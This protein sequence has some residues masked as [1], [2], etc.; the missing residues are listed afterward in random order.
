MTNKSGGIKLRYD[1]LSV[2]PKW[3][4]IWEEK[5]VFHALDNSEKEKFFALIEFPY[6]S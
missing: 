3:Q 5:G 4:E 1:H 2:E 6:P